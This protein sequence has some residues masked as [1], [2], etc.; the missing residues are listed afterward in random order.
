MLSTH[1]AAVVGAAMEEVACGG[2]ECTVDG[3]KIDLL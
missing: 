3:V 1:I 2:E